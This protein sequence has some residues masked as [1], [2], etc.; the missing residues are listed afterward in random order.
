MLNDKIDNI[1]EDL[2]F[3]LKHWRYRNFKKLYSYEN[4][5]KLRLAA[6]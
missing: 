6:K 1:L 3:D 4:E 2:E 5:I